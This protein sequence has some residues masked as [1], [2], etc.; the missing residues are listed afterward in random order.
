MRRYSCGDYVAVLSRD[1]RSIGPIEYLYVLVVFRADNPSSPV[2]FVTAE[3]NTLGAMALNLMP[4]ELREE[5]G[6]D[7]G[8]SLFL[9]VF[10]ESGHR[11]LGVANECADIEVFAPR[12]IAVMKARLKLSVAVRILEDGRSTATNA[13]PIRSGKSL[14]WALAFT[15]AFIG[16]VIALSLQYMTAKKLVLDGTQTTLQNIMDTEKRSGRDRDNLVYTASIDGTQVRVVTKQEFNP[17]SS[18]EI[19]YD[20][21]ALEAYSLESGRAFRGYIPG[22]KDESAWTLF[23][24]DF[25]K[26]LTA[27]LGVGLVT[28]LGSIVLWRAYLKGQ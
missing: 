7:F 10:D 13:H 24:R 17:S 3:K 8:K 9:G 25:G 26:E 23:A 28:L 15:A 11:N 20:R 6:P 19:V 1:I 2:L 16:T 5:M 18:Q 21:S 27:A 14:L 12:A 4:K 22:R